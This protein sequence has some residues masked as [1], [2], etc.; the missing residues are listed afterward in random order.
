MITLYLLPTVPYVA[1][2]V[3]GVLLWKRWQSV[4]TSLVALG[5]AAALLAQVARM[6]TYLSF[7]P[8]PEA[9]HDG[10]PF[11]LRLY[12]FAA[13][14]WQ[15]YVE[16]LGIWVAAVGLLWHASRRR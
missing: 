12:Y 8:P 16:L 6:V 10:E 1:F 15:H 14:W 5:F 9:H 13:P 11:A 2:T 7:Q 4:A 3:A